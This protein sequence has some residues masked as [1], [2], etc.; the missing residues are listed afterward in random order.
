M[1]LRKSISMKGILLAVCFATLGIVVPQGAR[2]Y[3]CPAVF[4]WTVIVQ[5]R[6]RTQPRI[7]GGNP[8]N[9]GNERRTY[10]VATATNDPRAAEARAMELFR[11]DFSDHDIENL[12]ANARL[13][14]R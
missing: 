4:E 13:L 5:A 6:V 7:P 11:A 2:G 8:G 12:R 1:S 9:W 14:R 3:T 10:E